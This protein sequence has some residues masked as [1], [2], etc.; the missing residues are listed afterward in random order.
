[1][2]NQRNFRLDL[3]LQHRAN[4]YG[5]V[6]AVA[7]VGKQG[8]EVRLVDPKLN[9]DLG[10]GQA[11]LSPHHPPTCDHCVG[12]V[13]ALNGVG[14][15]TRVFTDPLTQRGNR[16]TRALGLAQGTRQ[17]L[18]GLLGHAHTHLALN[19]RVILETRQRVSAPR[20]YAAIPP[21]LKF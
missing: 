8:A 18:K 10:V 21:A 11:D 17:L 15:L 16:L 2:Q 20:S 5:F 4:R 1:V 3:R 12:D 7:H 9:L 14:R 13:Q 19:C 6:V